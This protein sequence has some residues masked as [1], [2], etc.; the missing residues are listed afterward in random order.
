MDEL[1][2]YCLA[3]SNELPIGYQT[4]V[5][6]VL[7]NLFI[8]TDDV[9]T[10]LLLFALLQIKH[11]L[12][13]FFMQTQRMLS[14]RSVYANFGRVQHSG[15]HAAF[16]LIVALIVGLPLTVAM[17]FFVIDAVLHFHIDWLK[18]SYS[19]RTGDGPEDKGFWR[20]F[21]VDQL[22]H[23]LTYIGMIWIWL[24]MFTG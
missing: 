22:A 17:V 19:E 15:I 9:L 10:I 11:T 16:S 12:A 23:Q 21:G 7:R 13:D 18:G 3:K 20:A 24:A 4:L 1:S 6:D 14:N 2:L 5:C 8:M